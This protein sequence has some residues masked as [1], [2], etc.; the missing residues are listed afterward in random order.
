MRWKVKCVSRVEWYAIEGVWFMM[1]VEWCELEVGWRKG[2][3]PS[4]DVITRG[5]G[6]GFG[7]ETSSEE[8]P[9]VRTS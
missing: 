7:M 3:W 8:K 2:G 1:E 4:D 9:E 6:W 5:L